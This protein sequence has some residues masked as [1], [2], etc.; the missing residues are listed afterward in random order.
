MDL[1]ARL[2]VSSGASKDEI[3]DAYRAGLDAL[4]AAD[5]AE[6]VTEEQ[7]ATN[8]TARAQL[9]EAWNVLSDPNQR[10]RYDESIASGGAED[11]VEPVE[12]VPAAPIAAVAGD[13]RAVG[14][15]PLSQRSRRKVIDLPVGMSLAD[16]RPR[17]LGMVFDLTVIVVLVFAVQIAG[18]QVIKSQYPAETA[19]VDAAR[20]ARTEAS[21]A[22][23]GADDDVKQARAELAR[24]RG[25]AA[26]AQ[27]Q[28]DLD[29]AEAAQQRAERADTAAAKDLSE[30]QRALQGPG[31]VI[32]VAGSLLALLYLVPSTAITGRTLGMRLRQTAVVRVDGSHVG[33]G[34]AIARFLVPVAITTSLF[35]SLPGLLLGFGSVLFWLWD[36]NRQGLHD[37]LARTL[38]VAAPVS[39]R[40]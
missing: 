3:R 37:R 8:R 13:A 33:W 17:L 9:N 1:Y 40:P 14:G 16:T 34:G 25:A 5:A 15:G 30:A 32:L 12:V 36:P 26:K 31:T 24:A 6:K 19:R 35:L 18:Q 2:G 21:K 39:K 10:A 38:V 22:L 11:G 20:E 23:T 28:D 27:A 29:R 4:A 7:R